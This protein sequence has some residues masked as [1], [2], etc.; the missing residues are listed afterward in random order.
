MLENLQDGHTTQQADVEDEPMDPG[1]GE[2]LLTDR[3]RLRVRDSTKRASGAAKSTED[4][5]IDSI[6]SELSFEDD[7]NPSF[8][9]EPLSSPRQSIRL[10][11]LHHGLPL[12]GTLR[13]YK[14]ANCPRYQAVSYTWGSKRND[15]TISLNDQSF[16]VHHNLLILLKQLCLAKQ[17]DPIWC[18]ALCINQ[19]DIE[20]RNV[21]V[22]QM[23]KIYEEATTVQVWLGP[24]EDQSNTILEC[25]ERN[26]DD[27]ELWFAGRYGQARREAFW[28]YFA[29]LCDRDYWKRTWIVQ[30]FLLAKNV[31]I[32]CGSK[33]IPWKAFDHVARKSLNTKV[34]ESQSRVGRTALEQIRGSTFMSLSKDRKLVRGQTLEELLKKYGSTRCAD[35]RDR[36]F[37]LVGL[38][39]DGHLVQVDY[40]Q[41]ENRLW[42]TIMLS[43]APTE[44]VNFSR[45]LDHSLGLR[46]L[47]FENLGR[48]VKEAE[49]MRARDAPYDVER[50][51]AFRLNLAAPREGRLRPFKRQRISLPQDINTLRDSPDV[52]L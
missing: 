15:E 45:Q 22:Q 24:D 51:I 17:Q 38:A 12:R 8:Q 33:S 25:F 10:F 18:D 9:Y 46:R 50:L 13:Q 47:N 29:K 40:L 31:Q 23:G 42:A 27:P 14:L 52:Q 28:G 35:I 41:D 20:E 3:V 26:R 49:L 48:L 21:Q 5:P 2:E 44:S 11:T 4:I 32:L 30:E 1:Y 34:Y 36:V 39:N 37:G 16:Q 6:E 43:Y 7:T 19:S